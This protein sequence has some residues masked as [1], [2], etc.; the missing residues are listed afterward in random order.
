MYRNY[1]HF[2]LLGCFLISHGLYAQIS[3]TLLVKMES[4][5]FF[6]NIL[7]TKKGEI[8]SGTSQGIFKISS[9]KLEKIDERVGYIS[10][11]QE[12]NLTIKKEGIKN[13]V[14]RRFLDLLPFPEQVREEFHAGIGK[15]FY[16]VSNGTLYSYEIVPYKHTFVNASIRTIS[17]N[18]VGTYSGI[19]FRNEKLLSPTFSDGYIREIDG[20]AFICYNDLVIKKIPE[21]G[22]SI[23][24]TEE[25]KHSFVSRVED[26]F[27]STSTKK[28]FIATTGKLV[29]LSQDLKSIEVLYAT[30][31]GNMA[32]LGEMKSAIFL[33]SNDKVLSF[34]LSENRIDTVLTHSEPILSGY[35]SVRNV[36]FLSENGFYVFHSD[37]SLEKLTDL[38]FAH[39]VLPISETEHVIS[40]NVGLWY[41]NTN[42]TEL[43]ELIPGVEFNKKALYKEGNNLFAG[44]I[45]GLFSFSINAIPDMIARNQNT[46]FKIA[47]NKMNDLLI[48]VIPLVLVLGVL[49]W[50][51]VK[52]KKQIH[53]YE[54]KLEQVLTIED[55]STPEPKVSRKQIED[56]I[57]N[58]LSEASLKSITD[59]FQLT[60][61]QVYSILKP[62]KPGMIIQQL[63]KEKVMEMKRNKA[64]IKSI[65]EATGLSTSYIKKLNDF[66]ELAV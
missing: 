8:L 22:T 33:A 35:T 19:F 30:E 53:Y 13:Y 43:S 6:F 21:E 10:L 25:I 3:D 59:H 9:Q 28:Y 20:M 36:F 5:P 14:E 44:G 1:I 57:K 63:R 56:L 15:D 47:P 55:D 34:S 29:E 40:T 49:V 54:E 52:G 37:G 23:N 4:N 24:E 50:E 58:R 16:I 41:F 39:T 64:K 18:F 26:V 11:D 48:V 61:S 32:F 12:G 42:S 62:D 51:L 46:S 38:K 17:S 2:L 7:K 31:P 45:T 27:F 66:D 60:T 65:A